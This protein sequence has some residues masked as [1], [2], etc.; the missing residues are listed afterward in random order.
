[1]L[2]V[3]KQLKSE[4]RMTYCMILFAEGTGEDCVAL[5]KNMKYINVQCAKKY[6]FPCYFEKQVIIKTFYLPYRAKS[7][8][9]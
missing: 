4:F 8:Y 7:F 2:L 3:N 5:D 1:M 9:W 6:C